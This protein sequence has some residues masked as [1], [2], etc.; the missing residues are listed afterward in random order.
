MRTS[1]QAL[2]QLRRP[3]SRLQCRRCRSRT[4]SWTFVV[5]TAPAGYPRRQRSRGGFTSKTLARAAMTR[6]LSEPEGAQAVDYPELTTGEYLGSWLAHVS[7]GGSI[8]PTT[9]A[10]SR[11]Q[12]LLNGV[13]L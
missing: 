3:V 6:L 8:R 13:R 9:V 1:I 12:R 10:Y 5:D 2:R 4:G 11:P 7:A